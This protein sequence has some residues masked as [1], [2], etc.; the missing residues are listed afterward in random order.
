M[1]RLLALRDL[2]PFQSVLF[3]RLKPGAQ[4]AGLITDLLEDLAALVENY[5]RRNFEISERLGPATSADLTCGF[6]KIVERR[7]PA[8]TTRSDVIDQI[9]HLAL[10]A[11]LDRH[12]AFYCSDGAIKNLFVE[13]VRSAETS[14]GFARLKRVPPPEL[15]RAFMVG[16]VTALWLAGLHTPVSIKADGKHVNGSDL[17]DSLDP[18]SD[19][20]YTFS[21]ARCRSDGKARSVGVSPKKGSAWRGRS[22]DWK[23]YREGVS[24]LLSQLAAAE[25][26]PNPSPIPVLATEATD[27]SGVERP[28]DVALQPPEF[29]ADPSTDEV[30]REEAEYWAHEASFQ[31]VAVDGHEFDVACFRERAHLGDVRVSPS[32]D[33]HGEFQIEVAG[34]GTAGAVDGGEYEQMVT[35]LQRTEFLKVRYESGHTISDNRLFSVEWQDAPFNGYE[36]ATFSGFDICKEKPSS[37]D[38]STVGSEDSL[39]C[40][41]RTNPAQATGSDLT[42]TGWLCC[43]DGSAEVADFVHMAEGALSLVHVKASDTDSTSREIAVTAFEIVVTQAIKNLRHLAIPSL[44]EGLIKGVNR[45]V[46]PLVWHN[47]ALSTR[48][49]FVRELQATGPSLRR[50]VVVVQPRLLRSAYDSARGSSDRGNGL[51]LRQ[52]DTLL[53]AAD[54]AC[55]AMGAE[56]SVVCDAG[57]SPGAT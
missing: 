12:V 16:R 14:E 46:S 2:K 56:F 39:F 43:D 41:I 49:A 35:H 33:E 36:W 51:R 53:L 17:V 47:G 1:T 13:A 29:V 55:R 10:V 34:L 8:W 18:L 44:T 40:W 21:A 4:R 37:L 52:L 15:N 27:F 32:F 30:A 57:L 28:F 23:A 45:A 5:S 54:Q 42:G 20:S 7:T 6:L 50:K 11:E 19:W 38:P 31:I 48:E 3:W 26:N 9:H 25:G 24:A 22:K